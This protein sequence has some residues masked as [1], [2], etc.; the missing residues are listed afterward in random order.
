MFTLNDFGVTKNIATLNSGSKLYHFYKKNMPISTA[1]IFDAGSSNDPVG[2]EGLA[3]FC[4]HILF[5][6]T[7]KFKDETEVGLF[8]ESIGGQMNAFT[9][10]DFLGVTAEIGFTNDFPKV[11][12]FLHELTRNSLFDEEKINIE[13]G[14][15]L[16]EIADYESNPALYIND[17]T[18]RV[19]FKGS[20]AE[21]SIAG[22]K[23]TVTGISKDDLYGFYLDRI[24]KSKM[25]AVVAGD[26]EF[27]NLVSL[28]NDGFKEENL[29]PLLEEKP[30]LLLPR[31]VDTKI[32]E[33]KDTNQVYL[34]F[35]FRTCPSYNNDSVIL[36]VIRTIIGDGF[37]SSLFRKLR[38]EN[39]LVYMINVSSENLFDRGYFSV[40]TS[41]S[42]DRVQ[43]VMDVLTEEFKRLESGEIFQ[44]ELDLAK[45]KIIKSKVR[46]MQNSSS[47]VEAHISEIFFNPKNPKDL[48]EI[49]NEVEK[50]SLDDVKN[51]SKKYFS[52]D[53]W[54]LAMCG[55]ISGKD[56]IVNY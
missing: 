13:R 43:K 54:Y 47:W 27:S 46:E 6:S 28:F 53:K 38:T 26:I 15:I 45:N 1:V 4:E 2:K 48:A 52:K 40:V 21:R 17:L 37:S 35:S 30:E 32:K 10:V 16:G 12:D 25:Y 36:E 49:L 34:S 55:D 22:S 23:E 5:K 42:K 39:G 33:H 50:V 9:G 41:T 14:T 3:H 18:Q 56:F 7:K 24:A 8:I 11:V 31:S 20:Y 29:F 51:V 19:L 44:E